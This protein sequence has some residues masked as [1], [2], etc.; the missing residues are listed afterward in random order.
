M[1]LRFNKIA[2][3]VIHNG[4]ISCTGRLH[5]EEVRQSP[6][7]TISYSRTPICLYWSRVDHRNPDG[8]YKATHNF[9]T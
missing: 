3:N 7:V 5:S 4:E 6:E 1:F 9:R 8:F 2:R